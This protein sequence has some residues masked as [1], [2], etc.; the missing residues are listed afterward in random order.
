MNCVK[1]KKKN[2]NIEK[3][4]EINNIIDNIDLF[5]NYIFKNTPKKNQ[6]FSKEPPP[7]D[8][9]KKIIYVLI[10][11]ELNNNIY[12]EFSKKNMATKK[13]IEKINEFIVLLKNYYLKCK[14]K[15]YLENLNE[16]KII[17]LFRQILR[18]YDYSI[19]TYEKYDNGEKYLLYILEKKKSINIK[20]IDSTVN[21]D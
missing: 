1:N 18:P 5:D 16:K 12:Y 3:F 2:S 21:F 20:K 7:F 8:L 10:N 15:K 4:R 19:T 6:L 9:V 13:I 17:T 14:H 11:K